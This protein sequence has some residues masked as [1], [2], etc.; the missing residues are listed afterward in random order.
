MLNNFC[1]VIARY[2]L[3]SKFFTII[4]IAGLSIGIACS[5]VIYLYIKHE[6]SF[7]KFHQDGE[8]IYRVLRQSQINGM[9]YDIGVTSGPYREALL[10]DFANQISDATR[11][12]PTN[13]FMQVEER[14][15]AEDRA[16]FV[17]KNFFRFFSY[18]LAEG[19]PDN[20]LDNPNSIVISKSLALKYFGEGNP[21]GKTIRMDNEYDFI[22]TGVLDD[23][24]ANTH[25]QFDFVGSLEIVEGETWFQ[26]WWSN[27][28]YT[29][30]KVPNKNAV[31]F[32]TSSFRSFMDKYFG[33]DFKRIGNRID[34]KLE[35]LTDIYFNNDVRYE[36]NVVHGDKKYVIIFGSIGVL[37]I[38]LAAINYTNLATAQASRRAKE[39]GVRKTLGSSRSTIAIQFIGESFVL[40]FSSVLIALGI[41][42]AILPSFE[43]TF[44]IR[45]EGLFADP[46]LV[47]FLLALLL[48]M[49]LLAGAYPSFML[50]SMQPVKV[51]KGE[52][53]GDWN[54]L[55]LRKALVVVQ[56]S[57]SIFMIIATLFIGYQ[58]RYM[59][60]KDLGF[61]KD[62][63]L[64]VRINNR[65]VG[66]QHQ[67]LKERVLAQAG[68][69]EASFVTG[70]PGGFYDASTV[71][72]EGREETIRMRTLW[73]DEN[74]DRTMGVEIAAGRPFS[75]DIPSDRYDAVMLNETA[76]RQLGW[77]AE[78][79]IGNRVMIAQFD[80]TYKQIVGVV[81]DYHFTSLREKIEPLII[82]YGDTGML[83]RSNLCVKLSGGEI[84]DAVAA[85]EKIWNGFGS[86]FPFEWFFLDERVQ[87]LYAKEGTQSRLF[88]VFSTISVVIACLGIFGLTSFIATQRRKEIGVRKVLGAS[89]EQVS[90]LLMKDMMML[91]VLSNLFAIPAGYWAISRWLDGFAYR[92]TMQP[93]IFLYAA[94]IVLGIAMVIVGLRA[95]WSARENPVNSLR[96]DL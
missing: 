36:T 49:T 54:Y 2:I 45:L 65:V 19:N 25:L 11:A 37:L 48:A 53:R 47:V 12:L 46:Y 68:V 85:L 26:D 51:M 90:V 74:F 79:A 3:R 4:N 81:R 33:D 35:P 5:I 32:L 64:V 1:R 57:I 66:E 16:L 69:A 88:T 52:V 7:D 44:G 72:V 67:T 60:N 14:T 83:G 17:D 29:Y 38:V 24:P 89:S 42:Q 50:A 22:V 71:A 10:T 41:V 40:C 82:S 93:A 94:L 15:F 78:E 61:D 75:R 86:S 43:S 70:Y 18:P 55:F 92:A 8:H 76:V 28:L 77:T 6:L 21:V 91:V 63:L 58:L 27:S 62:Q 84:H 13:G 9:P 39:V 80:S 34:L 30:V 73:T 31:N 56:F 59:R 96:T 23:L 87:Q 95:A 20:V